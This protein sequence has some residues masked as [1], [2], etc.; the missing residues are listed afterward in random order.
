MFDLHSHIIPGI[1]DGSKN[2]ETSLTML[3]I[4]IQN[5]TTDI[6]ATPHVIEGEWLPTWDRILKECAGLQ[7]KAQK[8]GIEINIFPGG[9]VALYLDILKIL[10]GPGPYCINGGRYML[11][12]LPSSEIPSFTD[13]FFFTLQT[14]G[15]TPILAHPERYPELA[16]KPEILAEWI[17]TGVLTQMNGTSITGLMGTR[18]METAEFF[19]RNNMIHVIGSDAH[20]IRNRNTNLTSAIDKITMMIGTERTQQLMVTN[21]SDIIHSRDIEIPEIGNFNQQKQNQGMMGWLY[22]LWK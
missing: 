19:L 13:D 1:D 17:R 22:K 12:E 10:K 2:M 11:V 3:Q 18:V 20:G 4:A 14:R 9:E 16:K 21:P 5:G 15:I 7:K 8:A 6:V